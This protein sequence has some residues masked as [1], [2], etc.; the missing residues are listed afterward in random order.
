[1]ILI[2]VICLFV[3]L[4]SQALDVWAMAVTLYCFAFGVVRLY[5]V[6]FGV[7]RL[8]LVSIVLGMQTHEA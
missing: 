3:C 2:P 8:Y 5:F 6:S 4:F 7:V 1:M